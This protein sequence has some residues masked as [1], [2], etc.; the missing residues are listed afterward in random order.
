[1]FSMKEFFNKII[2]TNEI[3]G[4]EVTNEEL[5]KSYKKFTISEFY[6]LIEKGIYKEN[7]K[8][9]LDGIVDSLVTGYY[10]LCLKR[11]TT[12]IKDIEQTK[13]FS[14]KTEIAKKIKELKDIIDSDML[15][16]NIE[17]FVQEVYNIGFST[18]FKV[19]EASENVTHSNFSKFPFV[20]DVSPDKEVE[21]LNKQGRYSDCYYKKRKDKS[22]NDVY[23]FYSGE[24]KYL[25]P[26]TFVEPELDPFIKDDPNFAKEIKPIFLKL[27]S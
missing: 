24:G 7:T 10:L 6:E 5:I 25:K 16:D 2:E 18:K 8:E 13:H 27:A 3:V 22:G 15:V 23:V 21:R 19:V 4:N 1:M 11:K 17:Y 14:T 12:N 26:S 9:V 20:A